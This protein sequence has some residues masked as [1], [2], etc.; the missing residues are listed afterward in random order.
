MA[1]QT[2]PSVYESADRMRST[3]F[4]LAPWRC[5]HVAGQLDPLSRVPQHDQVAGDGA[6]VRIV[7][8]AQPELRVEVVAGAVHHVV[9]D[10]P[11]AGGERLADD[12]RD[13]AEIRLGHPRAVQLGCRV[14]GQRRRQ[15]DEV[16]ER[17]GHQS[18]GYSSQACASLDTGADVN[19]WAAIGGVVPIS[20][21]TS[22]RSRCLSID[23]PRRSVTLRAAASSKK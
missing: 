19:V 15:G 14:P 18:S 11:Q 4:G 13:V 9:A 1:S 22:W 3:S 16:I 6:E 10:L 12:R 2:R 8:Q 21:W 23:G 20:V 17:A 7:E 5:R